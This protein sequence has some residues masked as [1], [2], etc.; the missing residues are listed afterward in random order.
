MAKI[1]VGSLPASGHFNPLVP[2]ARAL[3]QRGHDVRWY[4]GKSR[5]DRVEALGVIHVPFERAPDYEESELN[6]RFPERTQ[7]SGVAQ[8]KFDIKH[9]F[10]DSGVRQLQDVEE[11][12]REWRP[13]VVLAEPGFVGAAFLHGKTRLPTVMLNVLPMGLLSRDTAPFGLALPPKPG[14][15]GIARNLALNWAVPNV[16]FRDVQ[17]HWNKVRASIGLP[18]AG[19]VLDF[20]KRVSAYLQPT[21]P[22]LEYPRS[23]LPENVRFIGLLP[24]DPPADVS[25]PAWWSELDGSRPVVHVTQGTIANAKPDLFEPAI[26]GLAHENVLVVIA[27]GGRSAEQLGLRELPKNVRIGSFLPYAE[28]L[29]KTRVMV[30]NGGYGSVQL[31]LAAGVPLV[32]AG[33]SEDKPEVAARVAYAGAGIDLHTGKPSAEQVRDAVRKLLVEPRW[34]ERA[35]TLK[36]EFARY[37][38]VELAVD[39]IEAQLPRSA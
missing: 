34:R 11:L 37:S 27:T 12:M 9:V 16:L 5:K 18:K 38:A 22:G 23:D 24:V 28:L 21:I 4:T 36:A 39:A 20:G 7:H 17:R 2:I 32:V 14:V 26:Q 33:D 31:A 30:T 1:L 3:R 13:D 8:L 10:V 35:G 29:P 25:R 15:L 19:W 6:D